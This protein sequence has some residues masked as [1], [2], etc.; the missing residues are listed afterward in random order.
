[1]EKVNY[2]ILTSLLLVSFFS[3]TSS[4]KDANVH[5]TKTV[6]RDTIFLYKE[7]PVTTIY[8]KDKESW[9]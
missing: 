3:C 4:K 5:E 7:I 8:K 9:K 2:F 6:I 1:M